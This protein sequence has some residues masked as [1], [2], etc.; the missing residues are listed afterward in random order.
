MKR[1]L[2]LLGM[3]ALAQGGISS[4]LAAA[5]GPQC[6][7]GVPG[8]TNCIAGHFQ[9]YWEANGGLPV[10]GYPISGALPVT[11]PAGTFPTQLF[12]RNRFELHL[13]NPAPYDVLLGRLG[14]DRLRQLG[15]DPGAVPRE[16]GAQAGC[17]W[18][19]ATGHN[20]C[21]QAPGSGFQTYWRTHGLQDPQLSPY[22]QS[23]ALFGL[24]LTAPQLER[25][26]G[27]QVVLTQWFERARFEYHPDQAP[28]F[29]VLLGLLGDEAGTIPPPA[30]MGAIS[31][32]VLI[33]PT[34]PGPQREDQ[35]CADQPYAATIAVLT[36]TRAPVT[37]VQADAVGR[38]QV[39]LPPGMYILVPAA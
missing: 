37:Q 32:Q 24:P 21:D 34:C 25:S 1:L 12:E 13:E 38:F 39:T 16:A 8:I 31:G 27:G 19:A 18:F 35:T 29:R 17:L 36:A 5:P 30:G 23:V 7:P 33:G 3:L 6:F 20:V 10:F 14:V 4:P 28:A 22:Q 2:I 11:S 15:R 26:T 9:T